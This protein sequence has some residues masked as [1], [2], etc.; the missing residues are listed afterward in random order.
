MWPLKID[1]T[2]VDRSLEWSGSLC[3]RHTC[4]LGYVATVIAVGT[5]YRVIDYE[6]VT[7][8]IAVAS[9]VLIHALAMTILWVAIEARITN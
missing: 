4:N 2:L 5:I 9:L 8:A 7:I 1:H 6:Q 3:L